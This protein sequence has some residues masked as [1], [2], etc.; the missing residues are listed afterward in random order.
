MSLPESWRKV[1]SSIRYLRKSNHLTLKQLSRGCDLSANTI[2]LV[3][4][5]EVAPSIETLCKIANALGVSP[6][7]LFLEVCVPQVIFQKAV[8][9]QCK[10]ELDDKLLQTLVDGRSVAAESLSYAQFAEESEEVSK[11]NLAG[12]LS[13]I[14]LHGE[15][16]CEVEGQTYC[17][18]PGD[19][20]SFNGA[21][22][23]RLRNPADST[24]TAV[25]V[26][27]PSTHQNNAGA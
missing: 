18:S 11:C 16:E 3:E 27:T 13:I 1:G 10:T 19:N 17:L 20:L 6:G 12:R 14:C 7:S 4:R 2:S 22:A 26:L 8:P 21:A 9:T 23:H 5:G 24:G 25:L 15:I